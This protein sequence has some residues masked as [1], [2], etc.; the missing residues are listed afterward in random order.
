MTT[1][2]N[3]K[4]IPSESAVIAK[5]LGKLAANWDLSDKEIANI[6]GL[7]PSTYSRIKTG[8]PS[9]ALSPDKLSTKIALLLIRSYRSLGG[10]LGQRHSIQREWLLAH[11][12]AFNASP[13]D[14]MHSPEG[15][16]RV[17]SYLDAMRGVEG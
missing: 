14:L 16:V 2:S 1:A 9:D 13:L 5:A 17:V 8:K 11:N 7:S 15:L 10:F 6:I 3:I 4:Q 12:H